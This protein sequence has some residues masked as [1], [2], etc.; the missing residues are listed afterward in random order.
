MLFF[1]VPN[2]LAKQPGSLSHT[3]IV[4]IQLEGYLEVMSPKQL[5]DSFGIVLGVRQ[6]SRVLIGG[7]A[8]YKRHT[9]SCLSGNS[10]GK[11]GTE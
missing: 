2:G 3:A 1:E 6:A 7:I 5:G 4:K 10:A 11:D 8:Y 9:P